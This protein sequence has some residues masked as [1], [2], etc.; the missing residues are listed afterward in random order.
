MSAAKNLLD[1]L[2][3]DYRR[4]NPQAGAIQRLLA[5]SGDTVVNDHIALRTYDDRRVNIEVL[6]RAF[7]GLGYQDHGEYK[8]PQKKLRARHYEHQDAGHPK[9]FISELKLGE[10]SPPLRRIVSGLIDQV[11]PDMLNRVDLPVIGRP[12]TV[13]R[14][15]YA[16]LADESEYAAWVA[17]FGFRANHFTILVNALERFD[18]LQQLNAFLNDQGYC[19]N[20]SGGQIKG[21]PE[22]YLEQ[23]STLAD[24]VAVQF[25]DGTATIPCG[26]YEFARRY[27]LPNGQL[28]Q[29]FVAGSADR[30]FESTDRR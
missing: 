19:L 17:A 25:S 24:K 5:S 20:T 14:A 30:I 3:D 7:V 1:R 22:V 21:S 16:T 2:W 8:F 23:S 6:A 12:W 18:G 28:F 4:L 9:V 27:P 29:G 15:D 26:Y 13:S 10:C 11:E